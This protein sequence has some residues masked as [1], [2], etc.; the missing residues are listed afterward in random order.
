[1]PPRASGGRTVEIVV[2]DPPPEVPVR[3]TI[4]VVEPEASREGPPRLRATVTN[5]A[6]YPV[7]VGEE[8]AV[9]FAFVYSQRQPG[10]VLLPEPADAYPAVRRGCWRLAEPVAIAEYYGVTP[11]AP[12]ES[13]SREVG[14][15]GSPDG[16]GCLPTGR[17]RFE[18]NYSVARDE[19][20]GLDSPREDAR[21]GFELDVS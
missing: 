9:V 4:E 15:W 10:V 19:T 3:P 16:Q 2:R 18:T 21:W 8:R 5:R 12:G 20:E 1:M 17:F 13:T 14:V 7:E 6:D 11:L